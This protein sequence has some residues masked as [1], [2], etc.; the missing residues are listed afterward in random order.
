MK[1]A[2]RYHVMST[3]FCDII[4][5]KIKH[6]IMQKFGNL[7]TSEFTYISSNT[8]KYSFFNLIL[9]IIRK[10]KEKNSINKT[11]YFSQC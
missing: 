6:E 4:M 8:L 1:S 11:S 7:N 9:F 5:Q 3:A 10:E 2:A